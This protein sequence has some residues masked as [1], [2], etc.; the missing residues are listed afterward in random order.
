[1]QITDSEIQQY[2]ERHTS[3][4]EGAIGDV[5]RS[6]QL[7]TAN[8]HQSSTPYQGLLL[9]MLS[10]MVKPQRAVEIGVFAGFSAIN[11]AE[12]LRPDGMLYAIEA[13]EECAAMIEQNLREAGVE[14]KVK[15]CIGPALDIIGHLPD[16]LDFVF[17]D[18]DKR[19]YLNY[20]E[21]ILPKMRTGGVLVFDNMLWYGNVLKADADA[22]TEVIKQLNDRITSDE[23]VRNILLPIR[24]GLM[25]CEKC[26]SADSQ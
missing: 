5:Y 23:R 26:E 21:Q 25:L 6:I 17:V 4:L 24:D 1:M 20:Y 13:D 7:H 12:G 16:A 10:R 3:A 22:E 14:D 2:A 11:I 9:Q 8:P 15:L 18:A 19:N